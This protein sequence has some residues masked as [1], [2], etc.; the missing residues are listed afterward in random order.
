MT[1]DRFAELTAVV[2]DYLQGVHESELRTYGYSA[3]REP[4]IARMEGLLARLDA[5]TQEPPP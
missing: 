5:L 1:T 3:V 4:Q 2:R